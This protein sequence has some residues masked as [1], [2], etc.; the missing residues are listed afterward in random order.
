MP[1]T[2]IPRQT[3]ADQAVKYAAHT[4]SPDR[5]RALQALLELADEATTRG[6]R[7]IAALALHVRALR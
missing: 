5:T 4:P 6:D 3:D 1:S 2:R 7:E